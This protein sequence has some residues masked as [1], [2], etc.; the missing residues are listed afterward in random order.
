MRTSRLLLCWLLVMG[1]GTDCQS[2]MKP[3]SEMVLGIA[4]LRC[5]EVWEGVLRVLK[6][7]SIPLVVIDKK[8]EVIETGPVTTL[9][10]KGDPYQKLEE[11]YR[12]RIK[13]IEP[14]VTQITCQITL[15]G[16]TDDNTWVEIKEP[17]RYE[18]RFLDSLK[19]NQ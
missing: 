10:L 3:S 19:L 17:S 6:K 16:L 7:N 12:I 2:R 15:R 14:L 1:M 18:K 11:R 9:P 8:G 4:D 13:C 5:E